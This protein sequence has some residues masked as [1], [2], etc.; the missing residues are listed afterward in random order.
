MD[1]RYA[2]NDAKTTGFFALNAINP[3]GDEGLISLL[4]KAE[5]TVEPVTK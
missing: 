4:K 2:A 1:G 5:Y 3:W